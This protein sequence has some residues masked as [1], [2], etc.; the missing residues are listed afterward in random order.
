MVYSLKYARLGLGMTIVKYSLILIISAILT[1][2][3]PSNIV[4]VLVMA[5]VLVILLYS[6]RTNVQTVL[7]SV[8]QRKENG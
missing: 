1:L 7:N 3:Y 5:V 8:K 4:K 2:V 6:E